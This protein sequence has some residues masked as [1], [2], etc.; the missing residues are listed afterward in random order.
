MTNETANVA[1]RTARTRAPRS[2]V[3]PLVLVLAGALLLFYGATASSHLVSGQAPA[4]GETVLPASI[5]GEA[6][7]AAPAAI[8]STES[9][10][11]APSPV[12]V[13]STE[14]ALTVP[15]VSPGATESP[16]PAAVAPASPAAPTVVAL[17][18]P[19]IVKEVTVG[20]LALTNGEI[21][22]TY[23]GKAPAAC[24]T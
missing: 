16:A 18:E 21:T 3:W 12:S 17:S 6:P 14:S 2:F 11:P 10:L 19:A 20:G 4:P 15:P 24:P 9:A 23:T 13:E 1:S 8:A 7:P 22:R 5:V